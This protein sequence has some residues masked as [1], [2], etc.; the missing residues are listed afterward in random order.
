MDAQRPGT[1]HD[2][3]RRARAHRN[4]GHVWIGG[5]EA[6]KLAYEL[7]NDVHAV[8]DFSDYDVGDWRWNGAN[9][10]HGA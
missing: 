8:V 4:P 10:M 1:G 3:D 5:L 9:A 6:V 2:R 7:G